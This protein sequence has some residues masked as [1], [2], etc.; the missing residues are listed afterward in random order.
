VSARDLASLAYR[1][2]GVYAFVQ[3]LRLLPSLLTAPA[4][5]YEADNGPT[6]N[7]PMLVLGY[8]IP[9]TLLVALGFYLVVK[10]RVLAE[11]TVGG[12]T[13]PALPMSGREIHAILLSV[14]GV[15]LIGIASPS[16]PRVG[17]NFALLLGDYGRDGFL[18]RRTALFKDSWL[19]LSGVVLQLALGVLL[20]F[21]AR[22]LSLLLRRSHGS[23]RLERGCP[24]CKHP[25]SARDYRSEVE[26]WI[27]SKCRRSLPR[28]LVVT[29]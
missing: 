8:F 24:H 28:E 11:L 26:E 18:E 16:I 22:Q 9:I 14:L 12:S 10:S 6:V 2:A 25:F 27:C 19:F 5:N 20:L 4:W 29:E 13:Q 15:L 7:M 1:L 21:R 3:A 17:Q 23:K